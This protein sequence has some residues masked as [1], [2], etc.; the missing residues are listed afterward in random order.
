MTDSV[1]NETQP[2]SPTRIIGIAVAV[3]AAVVGTATALVM[4]TELFLILFLAVLFGIFLN[5]CSAYVAAM[6]G[7]GYGWCLGAVTFLLTASMIGGG[8]FFGAQVDTQLSGASKRLDEA[9]DKLQSLVEDHPALKSALSSTPFLREL[10]SEDAQTT[11][12]PGT[13][14]PNSTDDNIQADSS[15]DEK[16]QQANIT[17]SGAIATAAQTAASAL[18]KIFQTTFGLLVN[19]VLIFFVG[20]FLATSPQTYRDGVVVLFRK[21]RRKRVTEILNQMGD[22]LWN[23]LVGRFGSML[24][25]G[26]G[27]AVILLSLG[28][29]MAITAGIVTSLL[30]FIPNIG[31]LL[32]LTLAMLLA[33]PDGVATVQWVFV[34]YIVLQLVESYLVTPLIQQKQVSL[35]PALLISFQAVMG[36]LFGFLGAAVA[37]PMLAATK[38]CIE[39]AY[40]EDVLGD[41][42]S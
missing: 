6:T 7:V 10:L 22:S 12:S 20:L 3:T 34:G 17:E 19:S 39:L 23:W 42:E 5:R 24:V 36:V 9:R 15:K 38:T 32:A 21:D 28:V 29:P 1:K 14:K 13:N 41:H 37:S 27:A 8:I 18:G 11:N 30:T 31:G 26:V 2:I 16:G 25:T 4:A 40:V 33:L 35:P